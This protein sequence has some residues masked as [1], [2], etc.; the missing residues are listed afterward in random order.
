VEAIRTL[1]GVVAIALGGSTVAGLADAASDLDLHVYWTAPLASAAERSTRIAPLAD[2]GSVRVGLTSW[3]L[4]DHFAL[5]GRW[6]ELIYRSWAEVHATVERAYDAGL[7]GQGFTTAELHAV[8]HDRLLH[9][10]SGVVGCARDQLNRAFPEATRA[11]LLR[12]DVPLLRF[13]LA[14]LHQAQGREDLLFVQHLRS[15]LQLLYFDVL[16]ALNRLYH[17]GEKRLQ[18]HAR[19]CPV[20]PVEGEARWRRIARLSADDPALVTEL[21]A[22]VHELGDLVRRHGGVEIAEEPL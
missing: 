1:R 14:R 4:E 10:P 7:V 6:I 20:R 5:G 21:E 11:A 17:P 18:E 22:L 15:T 8:A 12:H 19:R 13:H 9:D 3:G 2:P 16:F